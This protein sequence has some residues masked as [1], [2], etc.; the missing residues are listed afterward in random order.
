MDKIGCN[1][2]VD[3]EVSNGSRLWCETDS[4]GRS[5]VPFGFRSMLTY[6]CI[7]GRDTESLSVML[8]NCNI[9]KH[10]E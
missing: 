10:K 6:L 7:N 4:G 3:G 2:A 8:H 1:L 5:D 9:K